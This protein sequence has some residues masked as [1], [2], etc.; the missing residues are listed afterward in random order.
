MHNRQGHFFILH[1]D[2]VRMVD[3]VGEHYVFLPT[4]CTRI[5]GLILFALAS[6]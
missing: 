1:F 6:K 4:R 5:S 3:G 2:L